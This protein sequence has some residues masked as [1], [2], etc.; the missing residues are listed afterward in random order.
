MEE[1]DVVEIMLVLGVVGVRE[2]EVVVV[3]DI[4]NCRNTR[5]PGLLNQGSPLKFAAAARLLYG[6]KKR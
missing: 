6:K 5:F 1:V 3:L 4:V 2:V